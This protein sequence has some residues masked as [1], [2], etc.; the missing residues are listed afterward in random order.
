MDDKILNQNPTPPI[1][2]YQGQ[3]K[4]KNKGKKTLLLILVLILIAAAVFIF[5][6][7]DDN[8]K[9]QE[10]SNNQ[11]TFTVPIVK[12]TLL[13]NSKISFPEIEKESVI[14]AKNISKDL[15]EIINTASSTNMEVK[16]ITYV[17]GGK[18]QIIKFDIKKPLSNFFQDLMSES[19]NKSWKILFASKAN[20]ATILEIENKNLVVRILASELTKESTDVY[21]QTVQ[22]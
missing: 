7:Y 9:K 16:E 20:L 17:D 18:G 21:I 14:D 10:V 13:V 19:L 2:V 11:Q 6:Y 4:P 15:R 1:S 12:S 22:K 8:N 5:F 3:F